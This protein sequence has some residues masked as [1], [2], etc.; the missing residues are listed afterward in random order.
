[1]DMNIKKP[2]ELLHITVHG[3]VLFYTSYAQ[4]TEF[5]SLGGSTAAVAF[6]LAFR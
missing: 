1:M 4:H 6:Y 3:S 2:K 5:H